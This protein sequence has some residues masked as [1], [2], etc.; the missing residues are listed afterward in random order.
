MYWHMKTWWTLPCYGIVTHTDVC[1]LLHRK[2]FQRDWA[3]TRTPC[4][5]SN[6]SWPPRPLRWPLHSLL[7]TPPSP[8]SPSSSRLPLAGT[9]T[10]FPHTS[11]SSPSPSFLTGSPLSGYNP[12]EHQRPPRT[13]PLGSGFATSHSDGR[14]WIKFWQWVWPRSPPTGWE[15]FLTLVP[16]SVLSPR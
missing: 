13:G 14:S 4:L 15:H 5:P 2:Q 12:W 6:T 3:T 11:P 16:S 7:L 1:L 9:P 8:P 10:P